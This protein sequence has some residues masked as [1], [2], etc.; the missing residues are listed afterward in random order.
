MTPAGEVQKWDGLSTVQ[1]LHQQV[2]LHW[3]SVQ[4]WYI[5]FFLKSEI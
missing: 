5:A 2:I 1:S 3:N 4:I